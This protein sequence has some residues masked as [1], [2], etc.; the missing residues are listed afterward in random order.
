MEK[1]GK[2]EGRDVSFQ[3]VVDD[4]FAVGNGVLVGR[5]ENK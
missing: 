4:I 3:M 5:P 2:Y 1:R